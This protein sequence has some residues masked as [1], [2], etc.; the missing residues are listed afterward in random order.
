ME[1]KTTVRTSSHP[2]GWLVSKEQ[3]ITNVGEYVEKLESSYTA[4]RNVKWYSLF[5]KSGS[6]SKS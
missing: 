5:G 3:I 4:S 2:T 6:F 1:T